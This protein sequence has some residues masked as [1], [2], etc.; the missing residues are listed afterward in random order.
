MKNSDKKH[1]RSL[2]VIGIRGF[3]GVQ[4]GVESHCEQLIPRLARQLH[5]RVFRRKPYLTD[6]SHTEIPGVSFTD[7]TSTRIGGFESLWHTFKASLRLI[8]SRPDVVNVH[9]IGPGLFTPL[10]R[11]AGLK[12]VLTYHSPNYEHDKWSAPAKLLLRV[13]EKLSLGFANHIIFVSPVQR[14]RYSEKILRKSTAIPNG[15]TP[16]GIDRNTGFL[17]RHSLRPGGYILAVGRLTPEKGFDNLI[18]AVNLLPDPHA[19][20]VIAGSADHNP[21]YLDYLKSL[22]THSRTLFTGYT[23]GADLAQLYTHASLYVLSSHNEGFP[24]VLLEAMSHD[25]PIVSTDIPAA[26]IIPLPAENY[27]K[28]RDPQA[29]A[30]AIARVLEKQERPTYDLTPYDWD[31]IATQTLEIY[32]PLLRE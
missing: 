6:A 13:A 16:I 17:E 11:L 23:Y 3:P 25:L 24:M 28:D 31:N 29:M 27:C 21:A 12:V 14:A 7:L 9:N 5:C 22:D 4:G 15:I 8:L 2:A 30:D 20:L 32:R 10:L 18:R 26:H 19:R 1:N